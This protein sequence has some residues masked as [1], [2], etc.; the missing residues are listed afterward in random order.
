MEIGHHQ[1][2]QPSRFR[3]LKSQEI[4]QTVQESQDQLVG[5]RLEVM[6]S[7]SDSNRCSQKACQ[8]RHKTENFGR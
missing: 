3:H 1:L 5:L 4:L 8:S 2:L 6:Q 7:Y